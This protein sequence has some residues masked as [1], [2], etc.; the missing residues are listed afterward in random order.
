M[1]G[2]NSNENN[3]QEI[4]KIFLKKINKTSKPLIIAIYIYKR[5]NKELSVFAISNESN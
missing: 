4:K 5:D 3:K 1:G 2:I